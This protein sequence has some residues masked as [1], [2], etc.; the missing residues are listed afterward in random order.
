MTDQEEKALRYDKR[1]RGI[2]LKKR[3]ATIGERLREYADEWSKLGRTFTNYDTHTFRGHNDS[4]LMLNQKPN[5]SWRPTSKPG[6][7]IE[8]EVANVNISWLDSAALI[9]LMKELE[10]AKQELA[11]IREFCQKIGDPLN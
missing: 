2:E 1:Q 9:Q 3:V 5:E 11:G 7:P 8:Y 10:D 6:Q 4:I